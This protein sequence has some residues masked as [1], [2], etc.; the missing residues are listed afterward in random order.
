M[1]YCGKWVRLY[2]PSAGL[3]CFDA[4]L[5]G[6]RHYFYGVWLKLFVPTTNAFVLKDHVFSNKA[7][8]RCDP[9]LF[10]SPFGARCPF[11]FDLFRIF[12]LGQSVFSVDAFFLLLFFQNTTLSLHIVFSFIHTG[13]RYC[14]EDRFSF[15]RQVMYLFS[16]CSLFIFNA[17]HRPKFFLICKTRV[18]MQS[19]C[20]M[21][22]ADYCLPWNGQPRYV[23]NSVT[24]F[25]V[26][27]MFFCVVNQPVGQQDRMV[28]FCSE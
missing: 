25:L 16:S 5:L 6:F 9:L 23:R 8:T 13:Y 19:A 28:C 3:L 1:T 27:S 26:A 15:K 20:V 17:Q 4:F 7:P 14:F 18:S 22:K 10:F 21:A 11:V 2:A 24:F 12:A